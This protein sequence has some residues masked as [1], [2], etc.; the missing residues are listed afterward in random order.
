MDVT[1]AYPGV[2]RGKYGQDY[3]T[4]RSIFMDNVPPPEVICHVRFFD[5]RKD[6]PLRANRARQQDVGMTTE[7][8]RE[9]AKAAT[10]H[11]EL[12][13]PSE[14]DKA[15]F[16]L[17]LR[18]RWMEKDAWIDEWHSRGGRGPL[19]RGASIEE[20]VFPIQLK[21]ALGFL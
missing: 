20:V 2:P 15:V 12:L 6:I 10:K 7:Q 16:N 21:G 14:E 17:W 5:V 1:M 11:P 19:V 18:E 4:L 8:R 9:A 3:Y 13:E